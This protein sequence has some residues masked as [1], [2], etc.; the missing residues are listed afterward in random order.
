MDEVLPRRGKTTIAP[1]VLVTIARLS[2]LSVPGVARMSTAPIAVDRLFQRN[3][4]EGVRLEVRGHSVLVDLHVVIQH[5]V[6]VREVGREV[7]SAV[8]RAIQD[9]VGM[10]VL[11]VNVHIA[12]VAFPEVPAKLEKA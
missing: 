12:D 8:T 2:A 5:H 7:Q 11:A 9:M 4:N 3:A 6:S 1:D 10:Q